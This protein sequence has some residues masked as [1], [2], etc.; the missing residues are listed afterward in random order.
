MQYEEGSHTG[1]TLI[2]VACQPTD[3]SHAPDHKH[4]HVAH[5]H[6]LNKYVAV[7][8]SRIQSGKSKAEVIKAE[9]LVLQV[10]IQNIQFIT[11]TWEWVAGRLCLISLHLLSSFGNLF[12][13]LSTC[14]N[15]ECPTQI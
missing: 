1:V 10:P 13:A 5:S 15:T 11:I 6:A 9:V 4:E 2:L 12:T 14:L 3:R 8:Q 7:E